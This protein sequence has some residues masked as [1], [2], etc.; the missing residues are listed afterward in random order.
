[1]KA[2]E[3]ESVELAFYRFQDV[4]V[5]W[6]ESWELSR[7]ENA[8]PAVWQEFTEA[9]LHHYLPLELRRAKVDRFLTLRQGNMSVREYC[10]QFDS[11]SRYA[12]TIVSKMEDRIHRFVMGLKPYLINDCSTLS[13][14]IPLIASKFEIKPELVKHFE[15]STTVGDSVI[16]K[17]DMEVESPTIQSI[18]VVNEFPD[19]FPDE[20]SG[21]RGIAHEIHQL[22]SLGVQLLDSGDIG[23][24]LQDTTT[25]S[26]VTEVKEFQYEDHVL[27]H[28]RDTTLQKEKKPFVITEDGVLRYQGRLCVPNV[29]GLRRQV[30]GE[31]HYSRYS[32]HPGT[33]K[34]YHDISEI[35]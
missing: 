28:Y 1:M 35:Y 3:T 6:Y 12:P 14:V 26:L 17:Q 8:P 21:K 32:I 34:M 9:F 20:L 11:L 19:T 13:Y 16:A 29:A 31:T 24:T 33:T 23:I 7:G 4:A 10:L 2:T 25:S 27:T 30:M 5:N 18:P 15:V 22:A